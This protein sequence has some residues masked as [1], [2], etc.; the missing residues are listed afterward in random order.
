MSPSSVSSPSGS[1]SPAP[2]SPP[3]SSGPGGEPAAAAELPPPLDLTHLYAETTKLRLPSKM[4]EYYKFFQIPGVGNLAGGLPN[5]RFFPYDTLEAQIAKPERWTPSPNHQG[6]VSEATGSN[7]DDDDDDRDA[8]LIARKV[9]AVQLTAAAASSPSSAVPASAPAPSSAFPSFFFSSSSSSSAAAAAAAAAAT[10]DSPADRLAP[11]HLMVPK[12]TPAGE[13]ATPETKID[14]ATALQ[15][16]SA[17]GYPPLL[18]WVR[19]FTR[20]HLHPN[21]V[22]RGGPDVVL[23]VGS[24]D[25]LNKTLELFVDDW[26]PTRNDVRDRPGLLVEPFV[27]GNVLSQI[28]PKGMQ[29]VTVDADGG[30]MRAHGPGGLEDVLANWDD[31]KGRRPHLMY[32]VTMGHNPTGIVLSLERRKE[33]YAVCSRYDVVIVEDDPYWYLQF[34]S[35][36]INEAA[37][38]NYLQPRLPLVPANSG[39]PAAAAAEGVTSSGFA[40]LDSLVPSFLRIDVDGRV[41]RLDTFSKTVAPGCRLGWITAQPALIERYTRISETGT[42][43]PSGF[44]QALI[45]EL[46]MGPLPAAAVATKTTSPPSS[47]SLSKNKDSKTAPAFGG[48]QMGGWVRWLEGLRGEYERRMNRM[49]TILDEGAFQLKQGTPVRP[50]DADW[51]VITKTQLY[52]FDWPRGGMF[53]WLRVYFETHPLWQAPRSSVSVSASASSSASLA[54]LSSF[55]AAAGD[56]GDSGVLDGSAFSLALMLYLTTKPHLVLVSPGT[57]FSANEEVRLARGWGYFRLC[58]AAETEENVDACSKRLVAAIHK[59]WKIKRVQEIE[60]LLDNIPVAAAD[61]AAAGQ[62]GTLGNLGTWLGC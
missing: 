59:F 9:A 1:K 32:T 31:A 54:S 18:S 62:A 22:Y 28:A 51:G 20:D 27:Y 48:W 21:H 56:D 14:L 4:K 29:V 8:V 6:D 47:S 60:D 11:A 35:A 17:D 43:Q 33:L 7:D 46:V 36:A 3:A 39:G 53:I 37:S 61:V 58:F 38:R 45:S 24:T 40:F 10:S 15:Y 42:Q 16:G 12:A 23:T 50:S 26:S 5:V 25:G 55:A 19:Q 44:V 2:A 52:S 34:P 13:P 57:M 41:V 30:G 49:C